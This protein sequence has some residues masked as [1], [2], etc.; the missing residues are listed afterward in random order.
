MGALELIVILI[1]LVL[2]GSLITGI[3]MWS[4]SGSG[5]SGEMSCG[6]CGYP[7]RGLS[8]LN[9]PECG[10]DLRKVGINKGAGAGKKATGM[11]LTIGSLAAFVLCLLLVGFLFLA[12]PRS[13]TALPAAQSLPAQ[14]QSTSG[15]STTSDVADGALEPDDNTANDSESGNRSDPNGTP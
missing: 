12:Q 4:T 10:A 7:V 13:S 6:A 14:S 3:V 11:I 9:C 8:Q 5:G 15:T 2:L 1:V